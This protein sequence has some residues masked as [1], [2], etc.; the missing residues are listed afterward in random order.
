MEDR[1]AVLDGR[2]ASTGE[3]A[4]VSRTIDE[5]DD[6]CG[7]IA[8]AQK[9][10]M[11]RMSFPR[12]IDGASCGD[13]CLREYLSPK[14]APRAEIAIEPAIDIDFEGFELKQVEQVGDDGHGSAVRAM[15][16]SRWPKSR[17]V[18]AASAST[19]LECLRMTGK[20]LS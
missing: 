20:C 1:F 12:R 16:V 10:A 14:D 7:Q 19:S 13:K 3:T 17:D 18:E 8:G 2:D 6:R 4:T 9:V 5:V 11:H 15:A